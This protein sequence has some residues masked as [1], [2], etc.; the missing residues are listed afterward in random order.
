MEED[1]KL[2]DVVAWGQRDDDDARLPYKDGVW[3]V[4]EPANRPDRTHWLVV[5]YL[6]A[7]EWGMHL[8]L[9]AWLHRE[10]SKHNVKSI[11]IYPTHVII[12]VRESSEQAQKLYSDLIEALDD[13]TAQPTA[14]VTP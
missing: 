6:H 8:R 1:T 3:L 2:V 9:L 10:I 4:Q 12:S 5:A 7:F 11:R 13:Q 14:E